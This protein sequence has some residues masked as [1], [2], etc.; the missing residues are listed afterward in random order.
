M[1]VKSLSNPFDPNTDLTHTSS[2]CCGGSCSH[3]PEE[4]AAIQATKISSRLLTVGNGTEDRDRR[5][6]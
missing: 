1:S 4:T 2:S 3:T 6:S 5:Y